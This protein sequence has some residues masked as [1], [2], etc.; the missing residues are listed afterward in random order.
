MGSWVVL[1]LL[2][3][4]FAFFCSPILPLEASIPCTVAFFLFCFASA[5][6]GFMACV[7]DPMDLHL[8]K[9]LRNNNNHHHHH[10]NNSSSGSNGYTSGL[11]E[12]PENEETKYCWVCE[13]TVAEHS[14]HCKYCNKCVSHFDH[15]CQWLNT[16]I[17]RANYKYFYA[18]L[19]SITGVLSVHIGVMVG[20]IL[21]IFLHGVTEETADDWFS[22]GLSEL[23]A[24]VN[25]F[26]VLFDASALTLIVQ[27]LMFHIMLRRKGLSTYRYILK[28]NERKREKAK[29]TAALQARRIVDIQRAKQKKESC[30]AFRLKCGG[31]CRQAGCIVCDPLQ[32]DD[33]EIP[34]RGE[35]ATSYDMQDNDE[36]YDEEGP[37]SSSS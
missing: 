29:F 9:H 34:T 31:L 32:D 21:D 14:M 37:V 24:G 15:H 17:G 10:Q 12:P 30:T 22:L 18:T 35:G 6:F 20:I 8:A 1:P 19:W 2:M 23:V 36:D 11:P 27:L 26:F 4:Q 33:I 13:T 5:Y 3:I 16:C 7:T 25:I 28:D